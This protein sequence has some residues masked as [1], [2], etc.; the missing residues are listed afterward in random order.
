VNALSMNNRDDDTIVYTVDCMSLANSHC[1]FIEV[2]T[3][4]V[5]TD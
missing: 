3:E 2:L 1:L 4:G 5:R